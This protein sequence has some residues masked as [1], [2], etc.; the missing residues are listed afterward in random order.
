MERSEGKRH[1]RGRNWNN[2]NHTGEKR[3]DARGPEQHGPVTRQSGQPRS[4]VQPD[5]LPVARNDTAI[6]QFK[7]AIPVCE[8][9]G[10]QITDVSS[11]I[12]N[13]VSGSP[14]HFD[15]VIKKIAE[16]EKTGEKDKI[17]YI[18]QGRFAVLHFENPHDMRHFTIVKTI[19]WEDH[20]KKSEWRSEMAGLYSQIK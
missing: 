4:R 5:I 3:Q 2:R 16:T 18:G 8:L 15:C 20:E 6:R 1:G 10:Q 14:V 11:A 19:E 13:K 7:A 12:A 17:T 9:C